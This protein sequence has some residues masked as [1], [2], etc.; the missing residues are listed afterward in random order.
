M[1]SR[2]RIIAAVAALSLGVSAWAQQTKVTGKVVDEDDN[3][4]AGA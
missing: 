3:P 4:V 1:T 2:Y